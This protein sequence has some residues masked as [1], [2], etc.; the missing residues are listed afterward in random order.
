VIVVSLKAGEFIPGSMEPKYSDSIFLRMENM[1]ILVGNRKLVYIK[2][3]PSDNFSIDTK[4]VYEFLG[5][6][7]AEAPIGDKRFKKPVR[8]LKTL[9]SDV[10]NATFVRSACMQ[11]GNVNGILNNSEDC[12]YSNI[13]VPVTKDQDELLYLNESRLKAHDLEKLEYIRDGFVF[14]RIQMNVEKKTSMVWV[15]G[16][17]L[18]GM[19]L[20]KI[21]LNNFFQI[22]FKKY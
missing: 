1:Q 21:Y 14:D 2:R 6:P 4:I 19:S 22:F 5:L 7:F 17:S 13:W 11:A 18:I 20:L 15:H 8:M 3:Q 12:L 9:P 16:G 10:Y